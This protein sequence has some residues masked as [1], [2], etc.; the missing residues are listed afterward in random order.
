MC[1]HYS[2][3]S[4]APMTLNIPELRVYLY[5]L[6][7]CGLVLVW[8]H[9]DHLVWLWLQKWCGTF[10]PAWPL[11]QRKYGCETTRCSLP[12]IT[13]KHTSTRTHTFHA[14]S[15]W[16]SG[17]AHYLFW[18][19][20]GT[21]SLLNVLVDYILPNIVMDSRHIFLRQCYLLFL[22]WMFL[23][24]EVIMSPAM[25]IQVGQA[26]VKS[27]LSLHLTTEIHTCRLMQAEIFIHHYLYWW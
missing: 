11:I 12:Y 23:Q 5:I 2:V 7:S 13:H 18:S 15:G 20:S 16:T 6:Y 22:L 24:M 21:H 27:S 19:R 10:V 1:Q 4:E 26:P 3:D 17:T 9:S 14:L 25:P 8:T